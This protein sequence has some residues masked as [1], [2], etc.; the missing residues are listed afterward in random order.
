M[1]QTIINMLKVIQ[2]NIA[3]CSLA[4]LFPGSLDIDFH[5]MLT[6]HSVIKSRQE[7][8]IRLAFNLLLIKL[9][10]RHIINRQ[11]HN[12]SA[13][14]PVN[15]S[16][17]NVKIPVILFGIIFYK[18]TISI[19]LITGAKNLILLLFKPAICK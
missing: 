4:T 15:L 12:P 16:M 5:I 7:I 14:H 18:I 1:S 10:I 9:F 19:T 3:E 11:Q 17:I 8:I 2:V 13:I 6:T